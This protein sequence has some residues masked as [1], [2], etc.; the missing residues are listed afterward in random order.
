MQIFKTVKEISSYISICKNDNKAI[1]FVPTMGALHGGHLSLISKCKSE[2][3]ISV[4]SIFV[5]PI[6]FNNEQDFIKYPRNS[7]SDLGLLKENDCDIVFLPAEK[8]I[9]PEPDNSIINLGYIEN[10]MEGKY[11]P[12]HFQGVAKV[13]DILFNIIKPNNAY[14][15]LKDFQQIAIIKKLVKITNSKVNI[16]SCPII[17]EKNGLAM[18]SRNVRL[19]SEKRQQASVIY[20]TIS[21]LNEFINKNDI[22]EFKKWATSEINSR[23]D[24]KIEY[25]E[26]VD[27]ETLEL[28]SSIKNHKSITC[29]IAVFCEEVRLI[30][31]IQFNL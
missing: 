27:T 31:N 14:F 2:N 7:D 1:G 26:I 18:S 4:V 25:I 6:Q 20:N 29:C 24:F 17:R 3:D 5:N 16:V 22:S 23:K 19:T 15:G 28:I 12:G 11:R 8:E 9:Y 21:K 10:I 13:V 30:D